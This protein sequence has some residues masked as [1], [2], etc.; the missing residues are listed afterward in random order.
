MCLQCM[1]PSLSASLSCMIIIANISI[2]LL[3]AK[4]SVQHF[5]YIKSSKCDFSK[6]LFLFA[7]LLGNLMAHQEKKESRCHLVQSSTCPINPREGVQCGSGRILSTILGGSVGPQASQLEVHCTQPRSRKVLQE[8]EILFHKNL[9][10]F[11]LHV[12]NTLPQGAQIT[13]LTLLSFKVSPSLN[14]F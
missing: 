11:A 9:P 2:E 8:P 12:A 4:H 1:D 5:A 13:N 10:C 3:C 6:Q 7:S 14:F